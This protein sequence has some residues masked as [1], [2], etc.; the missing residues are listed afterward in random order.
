MTTWV[1]LLRL[2]FAPPAALTTVHVVVLPHRM[3]AWLP[4]GHEKDL[5]KR[6]MQVTEQRQQG[7][8]AVVQLQARLAGDSNQLL[9]AKLQPEGADGDGAAAAAEAEAAEA[10]ATPGQQQEAEQQQA[11]AVN[12]FFAAPWG[13]AQQQQRKARIATSGRWVGG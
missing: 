2:L 7:E 9:A 5:Q 12:P 3:A 13:D 1:L 11:A 8:T 6:Q 4:A 10:E